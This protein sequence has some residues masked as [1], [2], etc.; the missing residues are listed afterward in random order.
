MY[1]VDLVTRILFKQNSHFTLV[2]LASFIGSLTFNNVTSGATENELRLWIA[3]T[4]AETGIHEWLIE[5]FRRIY[6]EVTVRTQAAGALEVLEQAR[7]GKADIV[8]THHPPSEK[9]FMEEGYGTRRVMVMYNEFAIFGPEQTARFAGEYDIRA[10]M[11]WLANNEVPFY[12]PG[13]RSGTYMKLAELWSMAG[14]EPKWVGYEMLG[15]GAKTT[16]AHAALFGAY[17]LAD[18]GT[19]LVNRR[20]L[21]QR[22]FPVYRDNKALRNIY[23]AIVVDKKKSPSSNTELAERFLDYLVSD[24]GQERISAFDRFGTSLFMPAAHLDESLKVARHEQELRSKTRTIYLMSGMLLILVGSCCVMLW[25]WIRSKRLQRMYRASEERFDLAVAGSN[26]GIW[27]WDLIDD[28]AYISQR[29][30]EILG[31]PESSDIVSS[32]ANAWQRRIHPDDRMDFSKKLANY[33]IHA[34]N[35]LFVSE[36]RTEKSPGVYTWTLM[37]GKALRG[38]DG[39][40]LRMS[41]SVTDISGLKEQEILQH[42][43][44]HDILTGLPNRSLLFDRLHQMLLSANRDGMTAAVIMIDLDGFKEINDTHGHS[45]GDVVLQQTSSRLHGVLRESDTVGRYGGDEFIVLLP[46]AD[47]E[48]ADRISRKILAALDKELELSG[49]NLRVGASLGIALFPENGTE[50]HVLVQRAD[51]AMYS[52]KRSKSGV[53]YYWEGS[54]QAK[55][56]R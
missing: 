20:E 54:V 49:H 35:D 26:D 34:T 21:A 22:I 43:A 55:F 23:S 52:A 47:R 25:L 13:A 5:D 9:N 8:I 51:A 33:L 38:N 41:G 10:V 53:A 36:F 37:R 28:K 2:F 50:E 39:K 3:S 45:I 56:N 1:G 40:A 16:L 24:R 6:P 18:M 42:Q 32:P 31:F 44:L 14:I 27:D 46:G 19:Y 7:R 17:T 30:K 15:S 12:S 11:K 48:C 29:L 4:A